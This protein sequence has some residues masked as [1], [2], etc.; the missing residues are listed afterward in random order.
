[1]QNNLLTLFGVAADLTANSDR[2]VGEMAVHFRAF[3]A[4]GRAEVDEAVK[5]VHEGRTAVYADI[6]LSRL[7]PTVMTDDDFNPKPD[8]IAKGLKWHPV[9]D[10][11]L[12]ILDFAQGRAPTDE[13]EFK[14]VT[15]ELLEKLIAASFP[16]G[17][18]KVT[19]KD[20]GHH[21]HDIYVNRRVDL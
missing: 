19:L 12:C 3:T 5:D 4:R 20:E 14:A 18:L 13:A 6:T 7:Y 21:H 16:N 15:L 1:M 8:L 17:G 11:V 2:K 10:Y 9:A